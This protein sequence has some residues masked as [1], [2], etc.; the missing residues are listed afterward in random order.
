MLQTEPDLR[1]ST[2]EQIRVVHV[3]RFRQLKLLS[4]THLRDKY[5]WFV[6]TKRMT[7]MVRASDNAES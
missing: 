2:D 1:A 3:H 5:S 7:G 6:Y 4:S